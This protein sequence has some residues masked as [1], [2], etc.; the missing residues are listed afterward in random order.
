[1]KM[2]TELK[3]KLQ[4]KGDVPTAPSGDGWRLVESANADLYGAP[5]KVFHNWQRE[6]PKGASD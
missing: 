2:P 6:S 4:P 3:T 1:M 5:D